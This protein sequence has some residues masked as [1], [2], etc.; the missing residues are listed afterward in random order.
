[1]QGIWDFDLE[2]MPIKGYPLFQ[3]WLT[4]FD[5]ALKRVQAA[6]FRVQVPGLVLFSAAG[7]SAPPAEFAYAY[8]K[9]DIFLNISS[10]TKVAQA[11][12]PN[13]RVQLIQ[14]AVH[15]VFASHRVPKE[16]AYDAV[17]DYFRLLFF[18][19]NV[20]IV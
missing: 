11:L 9:C 2:V 10:A 14:D 3:S 1:L 18:K 4:A 19:G 5:D 16:E 6:G 15:D 8:Q 17:F 12:G 7:V 13:V 20:V